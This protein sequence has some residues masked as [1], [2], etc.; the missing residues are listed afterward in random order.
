MAWRLIPATRA[1][2][3]GR[4][5]RATTTRALDTRTLTSVNNSRK[6]SGPQILKVDPLGRLVVGVFVLAFG[7][8]VAALAGPVGVAGEGEDLGVVDEPVDHGGGYD[9]VGEGLAPAPEGQVGGDHDRA[10]FVAA[11]D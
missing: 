10:L 9:V 1:T 3:A 2:T 4:R 6:L 5:P 7:E 11:G 8:E